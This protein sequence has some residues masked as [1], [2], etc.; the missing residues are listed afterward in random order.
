MAVFIS[1]SS[2]DRAAIDGVL[3]ALRRAHE[4]VWFDEELGGGESWWRTILEQVRGCEVFIVALSKNMLESKACQAEL[5]YAQ[6]LGKPVLPV[7]VGPMD[8]LRINPLAQMQTIDY[9]NPSIEAGIE[10]VSS[11]HARRAQGVPLPDPLPEEPPIP[12]AY[13]M[14]LASTISDPSPLSAQQQM[15]LVA[16]LKAGLEED[17]NDASACRD[18]RQLLCMLR[19]RSDVTWRTRT[20]VESVLAALESSQTPPPVAASASVITAPHPVQ[21]A[22]YAAQYQQQQMPPPPPGPPGAPGSPSFGGSRPAK[23]STKWILVGGGVAAAVIAVI[24]V[25]AV[26]AFTGKDPAPTPEA[27][28]TPDPT[29]APAALNS[30]LLTADEI[31]AVM[32]SNDIEAST[33]YTRMATE[34]PNL[35]MPQCLGAFSTANDAVYQGTGYSTVAD[36]VF[37]TETPIFVFANQTAVLFPA[38]QQAKQFLDTSAAQWKGCAGE[39]VANNREDGTQANWTFGDVTEQDSQVSILKTQE[40]SD[41]HAC[42]HVL[43]AVSNVIIEVMACHDHITDEADRIADEMSDRA[44]A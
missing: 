37:T 7:L 42:Q 39:T 44:N 26:I 20:E 19:D 32:G 30:V 11:V 15:T 16:E 43:R 21:Q 8:N 6:E 10:L 40:A 25:V 4:Q 12:F 23:S 24:A 41:G 34:G 22:H 38:A 13:L 35:S 31:D 1:Y 9:R 28:P 33:V 36:Q 29:V 18:I 2:R 27:Q 14:R 5:R 3:A 17:G